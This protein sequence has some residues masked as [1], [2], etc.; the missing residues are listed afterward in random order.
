M[1]A[2]K[3]IFV[4]VSFLIKM[5]TATCCSFIK[6]RLREQLFFFKNFAKFLRRPFLQK[7][8]WR[9]L[10]WSSLLWTRRV[11]NHFSIR[12]VFRTLSNIYDEA[13]AKIVNVI[14]TMLGKKLPRRFLYVSEFIRLQEICYKVLCVKK[15]FAETTWIF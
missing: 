13:F 7:T 9:I 6:K 12:G 1:D 11:Q 3:I 8:F 5:H 4:K 10:P 15:G 14:L 2:L